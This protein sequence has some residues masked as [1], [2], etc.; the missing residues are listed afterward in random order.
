[1][2]AEPVKAATYPV[3]PV[4]RISGAMMRLNNPVANFV[5]RLP[6]RVETK[7]F[8]AF[9]AVIALLIVL[10]GIGVYLLGG[11]NQHTQELIRN[12]R[13]IAEYEQLQRQS[14]HLLIE[15]ASALLMPARL[16]NC[17]ARWRNFR[18][19]LRWSA[20]FENNRNAWSGCS[21]RLLGW[22]TRE[23]PRGLAR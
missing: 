14:H 17:P 5:A 7:L 1:M 4:A 8:V 13:R 9:S 10:G 3:H 20:T 16:D 11:I 12:E 19:R 6:L 15:I 22:R 2:V 18:K 23:I 21:T